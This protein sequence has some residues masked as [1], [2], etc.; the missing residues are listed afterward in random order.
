MFRTVPVSIIRSFSL[1]TQQWYMSYRSADRLRAGSGQN[2]SQAVSKPVWHILLLCVQWKTPDDGQR[3]C[4]KHVDS[5]F[6]KQI[7]A[8]VWFYYKNLS[9]CTVTWTSNSFCCC[10]CSNFK[11]TLN[12][13]K[14]KQINCVFM[15]AQCCLHISIRESPRCTQGR[16][17]LI[18]WTVATSL[19]VRSTVPPSVL[20]EHQNSRL[21]LFEHQNSR[22]VLVQCGFI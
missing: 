18:G 3:N 7:G 9:R 12:D 21:V 22:L 15:L 11:T 13:T 10:C 4:P 16:L 17:T 8:S 6:Q 5:L 14:Y 19:S 1:Y 2:C 20:F